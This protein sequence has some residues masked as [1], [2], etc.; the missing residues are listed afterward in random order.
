M[1]KLGL[2]LGPSGTVMGDGGGASLCGFITSVE[3]RLIAVMVRFPTAESGHPGTICRC[4]FCRITA[5][6]NTHYVRYVHRPVLFALADPK[7][8]RGVAHLLIF[9]CEWDKLTLY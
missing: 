7:W 5:A 3:N 8:H 6:F 9:P 2:N 4:S 1:V